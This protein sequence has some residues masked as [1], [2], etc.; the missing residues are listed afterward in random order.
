MGQG[1]RG[2]GSLQGRPSCPQNSLEASESMS[3]STEVGPG[4]PLLPEHEM[5]RKAPPPTACWVWAHGRWAAPVGFR[6]AGR[7]QLLGHRGPHRSSAWSGLSGGWA[8]S[9]GLAPAQGSL[10]LEHPA[11][12]SALGEGLLFS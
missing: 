7:A 12:C 9:P 11:W 5:A 4:E 10:V 2:A 3:L 1:I 8:G 6:K